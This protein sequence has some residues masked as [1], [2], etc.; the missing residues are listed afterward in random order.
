MQVLAA[1][2]LVAHKAQGSVDGYIAVYQV[3]DGSQIG[4]ESAV[5][6]ENLMAVGF[7]FGKQEFHVT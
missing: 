7:G 5:D 1:H 2:H 3:L 6:G 4:D